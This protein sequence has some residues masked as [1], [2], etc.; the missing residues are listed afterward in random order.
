MGSVLP[1][2]T[3]LLSALVVVCSAQECDQGWRGDGGIRRLRF[4]RERLKFEADTVLDIGAHTGG[5]SRAARSVFPEA[6][7]FMIE[8]NPQHSKHLEDTRLPFEIALLAA[9]GNVTRTFHGT[10]YWISTGASL[11]RERTPYYDESS[12]LADSLKL[13]AR[14]LDEVVLTRMGPDCCDLL[15][16]DVQ[17]AELEIL[18]GGYR[19]LQNAKLVLL[20]VPVLPYNE[21]APH[22]SEVVAFMAA[23]SFEVVD[24][25]DATY[26]E[27]VERVLHLDMLFAPRGSRLLQFPLPG[28]VAT[29][30][31]SR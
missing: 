24:V 22:F 13:T 15:K 28:G 3:L 7:F 14:A 10:R 29:N 21:G 5:W 26:S 31:T 1:S 4:F 17:G 20:E 11:Y 25:V 30:N 8:A 16:A 23:A 27:G 9:R 2:R 19:T 18:R 6:S 12:G